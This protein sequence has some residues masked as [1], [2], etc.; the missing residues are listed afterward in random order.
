MKGRWRQIAVSDKANLAAI[1]GEGPLTL[2]VHVSI[3]AH[4]G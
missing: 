1:L 2:R 4:E 3:I